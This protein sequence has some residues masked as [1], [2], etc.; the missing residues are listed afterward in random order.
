MSFSWN[1]DVYAEGRM[2]NTYPFE[3]VLTFLFRNAPK[4]VPRSQVKILEIGSG[5]GNNLWCAAR[6]GFSVT[7]IDASPIAIDAARARFDREGLDG[8]FIVGPFYPLPFDDHSFDMVIDRS[9]INCVSFSEGRL[10][11]RELNRVLK[12]GGR[13]FFNP[14]SSDHASAATGV[15][16]EDGRIDAIQ[17]GLVGV[18]PISFYR[19][20]DIADVL[21]DGWQMLACLHAK[22][23]D[24]VAGVPAA[25][26]EWRVTVKKIQEAGLQEL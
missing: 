4:D 14:Y 20:D 5:V 6:E 26:A 3:G 15:R 19:Y 25:S 18:G 1:Q 12:P 13:F 2:F 11:V 16:L 24:I 17:K 10:A 21:G 8:N 22:V 9:S 7:G 23:D